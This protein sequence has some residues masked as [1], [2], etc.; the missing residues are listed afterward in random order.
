M[1]SISWIQ[2][3]WPLLICSKKQVNDKSQPVPT[4]SVSWLSRSLSGYRYWTAWKSRLGL[5]KMATTPIH[6]TEPSF[7]LPLRVLL[8]RMRWNRQRQECYLLLPLD[9]ERRSFPQ[10]HR[11]LLPLEL[12]MHF[13]L[14]L[15]CRIILYTMPLLRRMG[16]KETVAIRVIRSLPLWGITCMG[17]TYGCLGSRV[18]SVRA[19]VSVLL[20]ILDPFQVYFLWKPSFKRALVHSI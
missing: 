13:F 18:E 11:R 1:V 7:S 5:Q 10:P 20:K 6:R 19:R 17:R 9:Q 2:F 3:S 8:L 4:A 12:E 14:D 15:V 16:R